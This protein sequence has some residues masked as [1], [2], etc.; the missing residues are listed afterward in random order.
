MYPHWASEL[1]P[2]YAC[3]DACKEYIDFN[4]TIHTSIR[5]TTTVKNQIGSG[6]IQKRQL[7]RS[8]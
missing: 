5:I 2:G 8:A 6:S 3:I 7:W 1:T 4:Y